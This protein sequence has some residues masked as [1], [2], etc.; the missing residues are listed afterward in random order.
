MAKK[1]LAWLW[2]ALCA[3]AIFFVVPFA[4][5]IQT[6]TSK[7]FGAA[8]FII[9]LLAVVAAGFLVV[10][11]ILIFRLKIRIASQYIWLVASVAL[12]FYIGL[13]RIKNPFEGAHYLEYGFLGCFLFRAWRFSIPD[14]SVYWAAL[15]SGALVGIIDEIVQWITPSRY[16][17]MPDVGMNALAVGLILIALWKGIRL[18]SSSAKIAPKSVR[19]VS[20]LI[21][22]NLLLLGA[23]MSNT[24]E[25]TAAWAGRFPFLTPLEKQEPM[26]E[27]ILKH[28]DP[29]IGSFYS[30]LTVSRLK[31]TDK[32]QAAA[33]GKILIDWKDKSYDEFL[34]NHTTLSFP[35]LHEMRVHLFRR[36][37]RFEFGQTT[38]KLAAKKDNLFIAYKENLILEKYF[39]ETLKAS[40]YEWPKE[41]TA[42]VESLIDKNAPYDSPVSKNVFYWLQEGRMWATIIVFLV[43]LIS[44]NVYFSKRQKS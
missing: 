18:K 24:P 41:K 31:K 5:A 14:G 39:G 29:E 11:Y 12:Y 4:R 34:K 37:K 13:A 25:R 6:F 3:L 36:D 21:A 1:L 33:Y 19:I 17:D 35:L 40:G 16:W 23:C 2:V 26:R 32:E 44:Y 22:A 7:H 9:L 8:F 38:D 15:F 28:E 20:I 27:T 30:R 10:L 42:V 43:L